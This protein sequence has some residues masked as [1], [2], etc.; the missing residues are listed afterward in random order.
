MGVC[1]YAFCVG[2]GISNEKV[3][4]IFWV[5]ICCIFCEQLHRISAR[6]L[7]TETANLKGA[8]AAPSVAVEKIKYFKIYRWDPEQ[9]QKPYLV[10][11]GIMHY[12][13]YST[14]THTVLYCISP[15]LCTELLS[16]PDL[17]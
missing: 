1:L 7:S 17:N 11:Y 12:T 10:R 14:V 9:N 3:T 5:R 13:Y 16:S 2:L 4:H 8:V 15:I 6:S